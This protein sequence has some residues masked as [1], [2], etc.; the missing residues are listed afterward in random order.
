MEVIVTSF[1]VI[2]VKGLAKCLMGPDVD[3]GKL[4]LHVSEIEPG[5][6]AHPPHTHVGVEAFYI[7]EGNGTVEVDDERYPLGPNE[8]ILFNPA[9]PHGLVNT[10]ATPMRYMVIIAQ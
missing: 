3:P 5:T 4:R 8:A 7:L 6:R 2:E 9:R 1:S 10:G